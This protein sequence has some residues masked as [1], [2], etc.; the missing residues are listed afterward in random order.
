MRKAFMPV[1]GERL[2]QSLLLLLC[3]LFLGAGCYH[4]QS[5]QAVEKARNF[6][7]DHLRE[8]TE[9]QRNYIRYTD[10]EIYENV[11]YPHY[12]FQPTDFEH[13][14]MD[15]PKNLPRR[16]ALD[17]MHSCVV[18]SPPDLG[19]KVVVTG[20]GERSM[21]FWWPNRV[22]VKNY[23]PANL[24]LEAAN[25]EA[26]DYVL[27]RMLHLSDAARN[28]VRFSEPEVFLTNFDLSGDHEGVP[29][30]EKD[31]WESYMESLRPEK[32]PVQISLVWKGDA[33]GERIVV[34]GYA[35]E[36]GRLSEWR[37][38]TGRLLSCEVL[39][40][41]MLASPDKKKE[42]SGGKA[43]AAEGKGALPE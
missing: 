43:A 38:E 9:V 37:P 4:D 27:S 30:L 6:A 32:E 23:I 8:L 25:R 20:E 24:E 26:V 1:Y 16:A 10:P 39:E 2:L 29:A 34:S 7:L 17:Y 22:L 13:V 35:P 3:L 11:I 15:T 36:R 31:P 42:S 19:A 28:R 33:A 14:G 21:R 18:W 40:N 5:Q 12:A 41:H